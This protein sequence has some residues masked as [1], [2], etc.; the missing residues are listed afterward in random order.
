MASFELFLR[1]MGEDGYRENLYGEISALIQVNRS[2]RPL[3]ELLAAEE[4]HPRLVNG[5]DYPLP[6]I[7][8]VVST[9]WLVHKDY[10]DS[11]ERVFLNEIFDANPLLFD[12]LVKRRVAV[13]RDGRTI[14]FAPIVFESA[15][16]YAS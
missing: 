5:S 10:L 14:R 11:E 3:R 12:Y 16:L 1:L 9:L 2:G 15:R 8:P 7:D 13:E 4:L 6:A